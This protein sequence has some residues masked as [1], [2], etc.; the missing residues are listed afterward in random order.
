MELYVIRHAQSANNA[1]PEEQRVEDPA[2]TELGHRQAKA[3][4]DWIHSADLDILVTSPFRRTLET[5]EYIRQRV[6]VVPQVWIDLHEQGGCYAGHD[7]TRYEGRPGMTR[8]QILAEFPGYEPEELIDASGWWKCRTYESYEMTRQRARRLVARTLKTFGGRNVR[9]AYIM[10]ADFKRCF[11]Q[12]MLSATQSS[13][14]VVGPIYNT[15]VSTIKLHSDTPQV[16]L[17]NSTVHLEEEL[18]SA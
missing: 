2:I 8:Q 17:F 18:L 11:L 3:L 14:S 9:V 4:A 13:S 12:E 6:D 15:A 16:S 10:H 5:T 7:P 1:L